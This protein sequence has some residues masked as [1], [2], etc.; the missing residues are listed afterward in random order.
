MLLVG[1]GSIPLVAGAKKE[2]EAM[3]VSIRQGGW[4]G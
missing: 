2:L 1:Q 3:T 4:T